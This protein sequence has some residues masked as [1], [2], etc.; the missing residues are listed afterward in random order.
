MAFALFL[1]AAFCAKAAV[2]PLRPDTLTQDTVTV[3]KA[4]LTMQMDTTDLFKELEEV[5]VEGSVVKRR[6]NE[7]IWTVTEKMRKGT[8]NA[9]DLLGKL[10][11]VTYNPVTKDISFQ[12]SKN[13]K[14]LVDSIERDEAY[15]KRLGSG[16]F[17]RIN[18]IQNPQGKYMGY[19]AVINLHTRRHYE[20]YEGNL[21][22]NLGVI[23]TER[24]GKGNKIN[25]LMGTID[26]TYTRDKWNFVINTNMQRDNIA[27]HKGYTKEYPLND[28]MQTT[29]PLPDGAPEFVAKVRKPWAEVSVDWQINANHSLSLT[30]GSN[31]Q[32]PSIDTHTLMQQGSPGSQRMLTTEEWQNT[33]ITD[34]LSYGGRLQYRGNLPKWGAINGAAQLYTTDYNSLISLDK[35]SGFSLTDN[36]Y[37]KTT[38]GWVTADTDHWLSS[39]VFFWAWAYFMYFRQNDQRLESGEELSTTS[40]ATAMAQ[41]NFV[42]YLRKGTSLGVTIGGDLI[43]QKSGTISETHFYPRLSASA[44]WQATKD[45]FL[46]LNYN[47]SAAGPGA[48]STQD[49]GLFT[50]SLTWQG[51]NPNLKPMQ[52]HQVSLSASVWQ[53]LSISA[54][55]YTGS[56]ASF[57]IA[58]VANGLRPDGIEGPYA[59]YQWQNGTSSSWSANVTMQRPIGKH[60]NFNVTASVS[61]NKATWKDCRAEKVLPNYS[62]MA[63]YTPDL[64]GFSVILT[65]EMASGLTVT[66]QERKWENQ[67]YTMLHLQ[68]LLFSRSLEI[69]LSW[70]TPIHFL[71]GSTRGRM[72]SDAIR[73]NYSGNNLRMNDNMLRLQ[74]SYKFQG[75]K[76]VRKYS[77]TTM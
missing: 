77:R 50:D 48:A 4:D 29:L 42:W 74:V 75:G 49:Y 24:P 10:Q 46:R 65:H 12:G 70:T 23:P 58:G 72:V 35:S 20:G 39:K 68:K 9:G 43:S 66:P 1:S 44:S 47:T 8:R 34:Y 59:R 67:D 55:Y 76:S 54:S 31:W 45:L 6:G 19:D 63:S 11:G 5:V 41:A 16:R 69:A 3:K 62:L 60:W 38:S 53:W 15:I 7:D 56:N 13:V 52:N 37:I 28:F 27:Q 71:K 2:V 14:I 25:S 21:Y 61:G 26:F 51:G 73:I 30:A 36:R 17:D 32:S 22:G 64:G 57:L 33:S 18:V 40:Q